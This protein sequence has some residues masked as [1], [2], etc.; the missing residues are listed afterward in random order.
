MTEAA[1]E[2]TPAKVE[3]TKKAIHASGLSTLSLCGELFRR[4][5]VEGERRPPG[6]AAVIGTAVH[7][8]AAIDLARKMQTGKGASP[9]EVKQVAADALEA[10]WLGESPLL[11]PEEKT[12]GVPKVKGEAK[13]EAIDLA[14]LH[15]RELTPQLNPKGLE[16]KMR[17][18]LDGF[19][20][21][22]EGTI[23]VDEEDQINDLK[24]SAK[25][26]SEDAAEGMPQLDM[27]SMM[28]SHIE[29]RPVKR[30]GLNFLVKTKV[31]KLVRVHAPAPKQF[32]AIVRRIERAAHVWQTGAFYPVDPSGPSGWVCTPKWCGFF[33]DCEFGR[34]R[35]VQI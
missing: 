4:V 23:D 33:N 9:A 12:I 30:Q 2:P 5:Y 13:D 19:P 17:L 16:R 15:N 24:T 3:P 21:D 8:T 7:K 27:Y 10:T 18:I 31:S 25:S 28:R 14:L 26:P 32:T 22:V 34:A 35:K 6:V 20:F 1:S 29:K 11:S